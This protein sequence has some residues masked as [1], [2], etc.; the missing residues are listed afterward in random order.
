MIH[1]GGS[2]TVPA[3][4]RRQGMG[5]SYQTVL[6][7]AGMEQ[8]VAALESMGVEGVVMPASRDRT[9]VLPRE[10]EYNY[11]DA[12]G[13]ARSIGAGFGIAALSQSLVDSDVLLMYAFRDGEMV[14]RYVSDQEMLVATSEDSDGTFVHKLDGVVYRDWSAI[15]TG[16][17]GADP[18][19]LA[20]FGSGTVDHER[21]GAALRGKSG[22]EPQL[23]AEAIH[24]AILAALNLDPRGLTTAFRWIDR[25]DL[26]GAVRIERA[27]G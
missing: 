10:G 23:P 19:P 21:L 11:A 3:D 2:G 12:P 20:P 24:G 27:A 22:T 1:A 17:V 16:P 15:P 8:T 5:T 14:H 25:V 7:V 6:V 4:E 13:L 9:A 18:R 26:P